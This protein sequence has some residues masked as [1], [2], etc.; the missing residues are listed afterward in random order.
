MPNR[1]YSGLETSPVLVV[2]PTRVNGGSGILMVR[3]PG[4]W[5]ITT[6]ISKSSMAEYSISSTTGFSRW[7]SSMKKMFRS[8]MLVRMAARSPGFSRAGAEVARNCT[9]SSLAT[10]AA[11]V[12]LPSPGGPERNTW[13]RCSPRWRAA[14]M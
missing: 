3:A 6:S 10:M 9:P 4:P 12:V 7:I 13:S 8:P 11:S 1:E 14:S 5:P 2:A